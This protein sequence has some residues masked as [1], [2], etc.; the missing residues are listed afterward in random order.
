M[1]KCCW[2]LDRS[3]ALPKGVNKLERFLKFDKCRLKFDAYWD[4]RAASAG[5]IH[6]LVIYYYLYDDTIQIIETPKSGKSLQFYNRAK[7]T[8][9]F[10]AAIK[11]SLE[12]LK[13]LNSFA[14]IFN[15]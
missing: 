11:L 6:D 7:L 1:V 2:Q 4:D 10:E 13:M 12:C 14:F 3:I 8:K 9:V 15:K 5:D